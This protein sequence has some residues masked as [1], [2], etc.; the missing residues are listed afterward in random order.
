MTSQDTNFTS[1]HPED[2][3][4]WF[5][6]SVVAGD[7]NIDEFKGSVRVAES[8]SWDVDVWG[9]DDGLVVGFWVGNDEE[10][11]F[12]IFLGDLV[13]K[14][15]WD[16]SGWGWGGGAGVLSELVD[17][18]LS[19]LFGTDYDD[20][21]KSGDGGNNSGCEFDSSVDLIDFEDIVACL[22]ATFNKRL[23]A[24]VDFF[25]SEMNLNKRSGTEAASSL[26]MSFDCLSVAIATKIY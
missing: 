22:I 21:W 14:G 5:W 10:S 9:F 2:C 8:N 4:D 25:G 17:S 20:F 11:R 6:N 19:M 26:R 18:S 24:M 1:Q 15:S 3:G 16:P 7:D 12:L 13:G 23:H